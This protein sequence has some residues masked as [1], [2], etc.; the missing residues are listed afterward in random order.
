MAQPINLQGIVGDSG[1]DG[2]E[3]PHSLVG[4]NKRYLNLPFN[5]G[6]GSATQHTRC[7]KNVSDVRQLQILCAVLLA[8]VI[9]SSITIGVV[10]YKLVSYIM[11]HPCV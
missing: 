9:G 4:E 8:S 1:E 6:D 10:I 3:V 5:T 7:C 2:Y 11:K